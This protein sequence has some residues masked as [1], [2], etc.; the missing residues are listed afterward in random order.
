MF[1][2]SRIY[3]YNVVSVE[4]NYSSWGNQENPSNIG[5]C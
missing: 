4:R 3:I 5:G 1:G 2:K